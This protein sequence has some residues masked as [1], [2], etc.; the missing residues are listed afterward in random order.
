MPQI[1]NLARLLSTLPFV[2]EESRMDRIEQKRK[3]LDFSRSAFKAELL[4]DWQW[5]RNELNVA[6]ANCKNQAFGDGLKDCESLELPLMMYTGVSG[7]LG[8]EGL[9]AME[10][11]IYEWYELYPILRDW[12]NVYKLNRGGVTPDV[13]SAYF[14]SV[15]S[16]YE[17]PYM[18][19]NLGC[20]EQGIPV[21]FIDWHVYL[22]ELDFK[23]KLVYA[24][25]CLEG[26]KNGFRPLFD[27]Q[28]AVKEL[29]M[30][31]VRDH[32]SGF[33]F[34]MNWESGE[35]TLDKS[36][37]K[38]HGKRVGRKYLAWVMIFENPNYFTPDLRK[39]YLWPKETPK[40]NSG[41]LTLAEVAILCYYNQ[42]SVTSENGDEVAMKY[43]HK[44]GKKLIQVYGAYHSNKV[45]D[46]GTLRK[47]K[48]LLD[49]LER[50]KAWLSKGALEHI[51]RDIK[52]L[53]LVI[54]NN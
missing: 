5:F 51:E 29:V 13:L 9:K 6:I 23:D 20:A 16:K 36:E 17:P 22:K 37:L 18:V 40:A 48:N 1:P 53:K 43:G 24:A 49:R 25:G 32:I 46:R 8:S 2:P 44:S 38:A 28:D 52:A 11:A 15:P 26:M 50:V 21:Q 27:T 7:H 12:P 10:Y 47:N 19:Q 45:K 30:K 41:K 3:E 34:L 4:S 39:T 42:E 35:R 14:S 33:P 31:E 54:E